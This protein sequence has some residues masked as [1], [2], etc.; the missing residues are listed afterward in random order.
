MRKLF[1]YCG[2]AMLTLMAGLY[3]L[4]HYAVEHPDSMV[5]KY[6]SDA[7]TA[8]VERNPAGLIAG[9]V[10][11]HHA[12]S[13]DNSADDAGPFVTAEV[14][15]LSE[16]AQH[17]GSTEEECQPEGT[18]APSEPEAVKV[19]GGAEESEP[20]SVP[21]VAVEETEELPPPMPV[22]DDDAEQQATPAVED[23]IK[24]QLE[25]HVS[26]FWKAI[27]G[28]DEMQPAQE[29]E[30]P[31]MAHE[32]G[33]AEESAPGTPP[34]CKEDAHH[35]QQYPACPY[36]GGCPAKT[37]CAPSSVPEPKPHV[38]KKKKQ[39]PAQEESE[40]EMPEA[41]VNHVSHA[42]VQSL[43]G[44]WPLDA[45]VPAPPATDTMEFRKRDDAQKGEFDPK[46]M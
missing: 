4:S 14:I 22:A 33:S 34:D 46:P 5:A 31:P 26:G 27:F 35:D 7:C 30:E 42:P 1:W 3:W 2:L 11:Q 13:A 29:G 6:T 24:E 45:D 15:D 19:C 37:D 32:E 38:K 23:L 10:G 16:A 21:P 39:E 44:H 18:S 40:P 36:I 25:Q 8:L 9:A 41:Q 28:D 43:Y 12:Q 20:V 17:I